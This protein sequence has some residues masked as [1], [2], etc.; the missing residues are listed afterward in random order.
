[1]DLLDREPAKPV[2][3]L[4]I[5][6]DGVGTL[7][8]TTSFDAA[9]IA[10]ALPGFKTGTVLTNLETTTANAIGVF[11]ASP[12]GD[13]QVL[14]IV[15]TPGGHVKEIHGV[16][17]LVAG[18]NGEQPGMTMAETRAD[19][20]TCRAGKSM[21]SGLAVCQSLA[22]HNVLLTFS[23]MSDLAAPGKLPPRAQL[24]GAQLQQIIWLPKVAG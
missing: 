19:P 23:I 13:V 17:R 7:N 22:A 10:Q 14:H 18:P 6:A 8:A 5:T 15:G 21:W 9:A 11:K 16:G 4:Q 1:M 20:A 2:S 3:L 12:D 24:E